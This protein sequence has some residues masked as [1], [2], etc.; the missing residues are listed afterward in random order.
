MVFIPVLSHLLGCDFR[1]CFHIPSFHHC[2]ECAM[3][4][5]NVLNNI[6]FSDVC[7]IHRKLL[8]YGMPLVGSSAPIPLFETGRRASL[9]LAA[10]IASKMSRR[11]DFSLINSDC[12]LTSIRPWH[13]C[14]YMTARVQQWTLL[15]NILTFEPLMF[16][17]VYCYLILICRCWNSIQS[18]NLILTV[19]LKLRSNV[20]L[21]LYSNVSTITQCMLI[22]EPSSV[23]SIFNGTISLC[24]VQDSYKFFL[25]HADKRVQQWTFSA[26]FLL[27]VCYLMLFVLCP[28]LGTNCIVLLICVDCSVLCFHRI[29]S[30][31]AWESYRT[32]ALGLKKGCNLFA[33]EYI[34]F[35]LDVWGVFPCL[36]IC[37]FIST[38][39]NIKPVSSHRPG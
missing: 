5:M 27:L 18:L 25:L 20:I 31:L 32:Q 21:N 33:L 11:E 23:P 9:S 15:S 17:N 7:L 4:S 39:C 14:N 28:L 37:L 10:S 38:S 22:E 36:F 16:R 2:Y 6:F 24:T 13:V 3:L 29:K 8:Y 35:L 30:W 34:P 1:A 12:P 19:I 26:I